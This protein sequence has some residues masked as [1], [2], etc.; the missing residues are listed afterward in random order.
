M[1]YSEVINLLS[2]KKILNM[3]KDVRGTKLKVGDVVYYARKRNYTANGELVE[4][5]IT[6]ITET[7]DVRMGQYTSTDSESQIIKK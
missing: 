6:N 3:A 1:L 5:T 7:G 4:C 2:L